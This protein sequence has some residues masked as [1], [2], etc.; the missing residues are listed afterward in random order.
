MKR[1]LLVFGVIMFLIGTPLYFFIQKAQEAAS[2]S[3]CVGRMCG[4]QMALRHYETIHGH[5]PPAFIPGPDGTPWH[6]W[7]VLILPYLGEESLYEL[8]RFDEPWNG[9][10]NRLIADKITMEIYQCHSGR[11]HGRTCNTNFVAVVGRETIFPGSNTTMSAA[12]K[13]GIDNTALIVEIGNSDI[14][15]M[16]PRDLYFGSLQLEPDPK[17]A[18]STAISSYHPAGPG[19]IFAG[20]IGPYRLRRPLSDSALQ[21]LFTIAGG[22]PNSRDQLVHFDDD[23]RYLSE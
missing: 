18:T 10:N 2:Q 21:S 15:W 11:E 7:R 4:I 1:D 6:S 22:E 14:H 16:E 12:I 8:Y 13:D 9:P 23:G 5:F 19:V 3:A 17:K 20:K